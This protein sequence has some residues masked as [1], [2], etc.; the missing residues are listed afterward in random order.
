M[1]PRHFLVA[2]SHLGPRAFENLLLPSNLF[3]VWRV[4]APTPEPGGVAELRSSIPYHRT[5][6]LPCGT[7][8]VM[9]ELSARQFGLWPANYKGA[10]IKISLLY[11][12][13][14]AEINKVILIFVQK[15]SRFHKELGLS[16][17]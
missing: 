15:F 9:D 17:A 8:I 1:I 4:V 5:L 3:V 7:V 2:G 11:A 10:F 16:V 14:G 6:T 13:F 12:E